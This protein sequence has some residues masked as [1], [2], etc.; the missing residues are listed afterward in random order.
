MLYSHLMSL[1][2]GDS[3]APASDLPPTGGGVV[4]ASRSVMLLVLSSQ[5]C[6]LT[7]APVRFAPDCTPV[8]LYDGLNHI[9]FRFA[10]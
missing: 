2:L 7:V 5:D 8:L 6:E 4:V 10:I 1:M 9:T 3:C